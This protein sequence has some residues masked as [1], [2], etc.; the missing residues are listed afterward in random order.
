MS[1]PVFDPDYWKRRLELA[2]G[3]HQSV[4]LTTDEHWRRIEDKH[5]A[6]LTK[7]VKPT[8]SVLDCGCGYGRMVALLPPGALYTGIDVSP[9]LVD[10]AREMHSPSRYPVRTSYSDPMFMVCDLMHAL[11][12]RDYDWAIV[13]S[14][15]RMVKQNVGTE[16]WD[17]I[18]ANIRARARKLL[19]LEYDENDEGSVE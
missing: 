15:R 5:R 19:Y 9:A 6:I 4:F 16:A 13:C 11:P 7:H 1:E 17:T 8:D 12:V 2:R 10:L 14:M 18:E 3:I